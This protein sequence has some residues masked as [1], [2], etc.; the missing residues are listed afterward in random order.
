V[1]VLF[2]SSISCVLSSIGIIVH[3]GFVLKL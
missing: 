1:Q 2:N 3:I